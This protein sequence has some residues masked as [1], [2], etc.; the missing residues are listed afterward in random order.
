[1]TVEDRIAPLIACPES[2]VAALDPGA[3]EAVVEYDDPVAMDNCPV[4][5]TRTAGPESG[6]LFPIGVTEVHFTAADATGN[7][8]TCFFTVTLTSDKQDSDEDG[9]N[10]QCDNCPQDANGDQ[11]D[12]DQDGVGDACDL[13]LT[14]DDALDADRD[15]VPD[16]CDVC[17]NDDDTVDDDNDG[18]PD[19]VDTCLGAPGGDPDEPDSDGDGIADICDNCSQ[20]ANEKQKDKDGDGIGNACDN[21][22]KDENPDQQDSDG[23]GTG[24]ACERG[25]G[26]P[27]VVATRPARYSAP[28]TV[29]PNPFHSSLMIRFDLPEAGQTKLEVFDL[30]GRLVSQLQDGPLEAGAY[31][32]SW[33]GTIGEGQALSDGLYLIRLTAGKEVFIEKVTL[34]RW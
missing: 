4:T 6:A 1:M 13:C 16:A 25:N 7:S 27:N 31:E 11:A 17:P 26:R 20:I 29:F 32:L 21:C 9:I 28:L 22:P 12:G 24:D 14:G 5:L 23:D 34:Q 15:E 10:N 30:Q 18:I 3:C 2:V 19:C 33:D 8:A